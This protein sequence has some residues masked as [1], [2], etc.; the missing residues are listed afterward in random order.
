MSVSETS[1][2]EVR[3]LTKRF[4]G[5]LA[6]NSVSF[7]VSH[8]EVVGLIG[9]N[10]AG[11]STLVQV[12]MGLL[13]PDC[14]HIYFRG[15]EVTHLSTWQVVARGITGTF[16]CTRPFRRLSVLANVMVPCLVQR[17]SNASGAQAP[18]AKAMRVLASV[19]IAHLAKVPASKLSHG[20]LKRLEISR[21]LA[22][23]PR[24]LILDEPFGG[25]N[26]NE[27]EQLSQLINH[28]RAAETGN[29]PDD[30]N[31]GLAM[32][33][34]EHKLR[35]LMSIVDRV[36]VL[37]FGEILADGKPE[38]VVARKEVVEAYTGGEVV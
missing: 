36:I 23:D 16:Q 8:N 5:V 19:G 25:L 30:R 20:D 18:E 21:A 37:H 9:P 1:L 35:E 29:H 4:G 12:L 32:I 33:V 14:G 7:R 6:L 13:K 17:A 27:I 34:I 2:L 3:G 38:E 15:K 22:T 28:L 26:P 10:G 31:D 24:L 11:K